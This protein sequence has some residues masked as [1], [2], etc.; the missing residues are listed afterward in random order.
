VAYK[1]DEIFGVIGYPKIMHSDYGKE[2]R[3]KIV[4]D[5]QRNLNPNILY[6]HRQ[7]CC[8]Q[9]QDSFESM[10]KCVKKNIGSVLAK[11]WL[12]GKNP[13]WTGY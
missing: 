9:H 10:N 5:L 2:F 4:L 6:V 8:P 13:N 12:L 1:L 3:T 7:P 11:H